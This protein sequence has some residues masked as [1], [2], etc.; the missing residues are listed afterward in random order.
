MSREQGDE[1]VETAWRLQKAPE[2]RQNGLEER[3]LSS[4]LFHSTRK[5]GSDEAIPVG[6]P[7]IAVKV[8]N[9]FES[10]AQPC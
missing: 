7:L 2:P 9:P 3:L 4:E 1:T 10:P 5:P 6:V 8:A